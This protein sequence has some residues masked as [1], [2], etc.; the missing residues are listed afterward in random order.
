MK[1]FIKS[2]LGLST[3]DQNGRTICPSI[4][5]IARSVIGGTVF[6]VLM[7]IVINMIDAYFL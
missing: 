7:F 3:T 4:P 2:L 5:P 6:L 1:C